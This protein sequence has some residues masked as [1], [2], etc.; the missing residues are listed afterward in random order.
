MDVQEISI[1]LGIVA[2]LVELGG[3][4]SKGRSI[5]QAAWERTPVGRRRAA[6][7]RLERLRPN[8]QLEYFREILDLVP[9]FKR[10]LRD[11]TELIFRHTDFY[12]QVLIDTDDQVMFYAVTKRNHRFRPRMWPNEVHPR[13]HPQPHSGRL[14]DATF[15]DIAPNG[16][17][18]IKLFVRSATTPTHYIESYYYGNPGLYQSYLSGL[19][20][21]GPIDVEH[22]LLA[23]L[24]GPPTALGSFAAHP[25]DEQL[26]EWLANGDV[27]DFRQRAVPN[28][29]GLS[30]PGF[31]P[32]E[33]GPDF[34][35][36]PD[37]V[38]MR[39]I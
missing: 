18:G 7:R 5:L 9:I 29:Y 35:L 3:R 15:H 4:L 26:D 22:A 34:P 14:G 17:D 11:H 6:S 30:A 12:V 32:S 1:L 33:Y 25:G 31:S 36:G 13:S 20:E 37:P 24:L 39:T 38:Q 23:P 21:C 8:V 19:N 28:T 10:R 2:A 16:V 27:I